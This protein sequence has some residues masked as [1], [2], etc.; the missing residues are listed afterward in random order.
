M[1]KICIYSGKLSHGLK[2]MFEAISLINDMNILNFE[3]LVIQATNLI[4]KENSGPRKI[5]EMTIQYLVNSQKWFRINDENER[6][7]ALQKCLLESD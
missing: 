4:K 7:D 1:K 6:L 3:N 2:S 5:D